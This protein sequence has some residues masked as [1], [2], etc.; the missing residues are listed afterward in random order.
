MDPREES[1]DSCSV[2]PPLKKTKLDVLERP[3]ATDIEHEEM[4]NGETDGDDGSLF[5]F[6]AEQTKLPPSFLCEKCQLIC[7]KWYPWDMNGVQF[8]H[9]ENSF[10]LE[11]SAKRGCSLC[12]QFFASVDQELLEDRRQRLKEGPDDGFGES[13]DFGGFIGIQDAAFEKM[14]ANPQITPSWT[15]C[16]SFGHGA[17]NFFV[18]MIPALGP[19]RYID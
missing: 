14:E 6:E 18:D 5:D 16:L 1:S 2:G 19:G 8:S 10:V 13:G 7:D 15:L 9:C 4:S 3:S 11:A 12:M 17:Q